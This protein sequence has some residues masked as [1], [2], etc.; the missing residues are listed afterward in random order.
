MYASF[1]F[2]KK[3]V[4]ETSTSFIVPI[5]AFPT[6]NVVLHMDGVDGSTTFI[7]AT[8]NRTVTAFGAVID[9]AQFVFG[10]ASGLFDPAIPSR[11]Y[12]SA[13]ADLAVGTGDFTIDCRVRFLDKTGNQQF[14]TSDTSSGYFLIGKDASDLFYVYDNLTGTIII[15]TTAAQNDTWYHIALTRGAGSGRLFV[16]GFQ[17][18]STYAMSRSYTADGTPWVGKGAFADFNGWVDEFRYVVGTAQWTS[19]FTPPAAPYNPPDP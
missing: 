11:L 10:N 18:G 6:P 13:F 9:T 19:N 5:S 15:G 4:P 17:E 7:D 1:D 12:F 8:G 3:I 2:V 16:D 14:F